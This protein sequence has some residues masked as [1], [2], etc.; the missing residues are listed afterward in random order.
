M[1]N[2]GR[3]LTQVLYIFI[4]SQG[5]QASRRLALRS[6]ASTSCLVDH[7]SICN[8]GC[9][10]GSSVGELSPPRVV[11]ECDVG[12]PI[13]KDTEEER[14]MSRLF[15]VSFCMMIGTGKQ[16]LIRELRLPDIPKLPKLRGYRRR[17][18]YPTNHATISD[19]SR[20]LCPVLLHDRSYIG[21]FAQAATVFAAEA[22]SQ[23]VEEPL[24]MLKST[25]A[26]DGKSFSCD[27]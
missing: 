3:L 18:T 2:K 22:G 20:A 17:F 25:S 5:D 16:A 11:V 6:R 8:S 4:C 23:K 21:G 19:V 15:I 7:D 10:K 13:S 14:Q 1:E 12:K 26:K 27:F 9:D 24:L